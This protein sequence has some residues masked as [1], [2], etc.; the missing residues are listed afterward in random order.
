MAVIYGPQ[1]DIDVYN[2]TQ[3]IVANG[4]TVPTSTT[5]AVLTFTRSL[6]DSG[7]WNKLTEVYIFCGVGNL[8]S[9]LSKLKYLS[10]Q[11]LSNSGFLAGDFSSTG[12]TCGLNNSGASSKILSTGITTS[13]ITSTNRSVAVYETRR[14]AGFF[15]TVIGR[16]GGGGNSAY[17][18]TIDT[19]GGVASRMLDTTSSTTISSSTATTAGGLLY[20][21]ASATVVGHY[22]NKTWSQS[23]FTLGTYNGASQYTIGG[24][25]G[26]GAAMNATLSL[27]FI[28]LFLNQSEV[29]LL[30]AYCDTLMS[31]FGGNK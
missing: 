4:G 25:I 19:G 12:S 20:S 24:S 29:E 5:S 3:N 6:K 17:G 27:G 15:T 7:L 23:N 30:S 1:F 11:R 26:G 21:G 22:S 31:A 9:T 8:S 14:A 18:P 28:G 10:N 13:N 16:E 2:W